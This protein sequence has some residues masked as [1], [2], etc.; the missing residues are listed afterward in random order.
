MSKVTIKSAIQ[1]ISTQLN[2]KHPRGKQSQFRKKEIK[3]K[4]KMWVSL[5]LL[6]S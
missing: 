5:L 1:L 4:R 2:L 3:I 6:L